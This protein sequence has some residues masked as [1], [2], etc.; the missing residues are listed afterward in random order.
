MVENPFDVEIRVGEV[1]EAEAFPEARKPKMAKLW[2]DL[3]EEG[4]EIQSAAQL[5]HHYE[6]DELEGRQVLCATTLGTVQVA[7]FKSEALTVCVPG[8][9]EYPVLVKPDE[10]VPLGGLLF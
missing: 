4:G 6:P 2:I 3:G 5:D 7:G 8:E 1:L 9:E 10:E